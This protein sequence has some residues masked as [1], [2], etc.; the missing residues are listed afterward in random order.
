[1]YNSSVACLHIN[2]SLLSPLLPLS[3]FQWHDFLWR[4]FGSW[5]RQSQNWGLG[6]LPS[7]AFG[8]LFGFISH[9]V[10]RSSHLIQESIE[11]RIFSI[12]VSPVFPTQEGALLKMNRSLN[13]YLSRAVEM[14][15]SWHALSDNPDRLVYT[16][17]PAPLP[18]TVPLQVLSVSAHGSDIQ[19]TIYPSI[20]RYIKKALVP[21]LK[22]QIN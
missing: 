17:F 2:L 20:R 3:T 21:I 12:R 22:I 18:H 7:Q 15:D 14:N 9:P 8:F 10:R 6:R 13:E 19:P 11:R 1:M 4:I 16:R 5:H